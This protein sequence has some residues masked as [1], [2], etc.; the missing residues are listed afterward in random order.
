MKL[1]HVDVFSSRPMSGNGLTVVFPERETRSDEL[2]AITREL[3]Q[4]ETIFIGQKNSSGVYSARIFT[5]DEELPFAGHPVL[6]AAAVL[7]R[8]TDPESERFDVTLDIQG[9]LCPVESIKNGSSFI[10]RM[11]QGQPSFITSPGRE[12]YHHIADRLNLPVHCIDSSLPVETVST[13][14]PYLIVP[15][16]EGIETAAIKGPGFEEF[17]NK[18]EAKFVYLFGTSTLE[19]RTWDNHG[20]DEDVATGSA[21]GPLCA[22]LVKHGVKKSGEVITLSQGKFTGR[23]SV[24]RGMVDSTGPVF[25]EGEVTFFGKCEILV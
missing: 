12:H 4:F 22:Y 24:I 25:I 2:L 1:Y 23:P 8:L 19:C 7:H 18:F 15:L 13:G 16:C 5:V 14:L 3:K 20:R 11:N 9:R 6:G 17:L 10:S 21:A